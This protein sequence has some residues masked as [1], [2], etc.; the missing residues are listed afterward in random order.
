MWRYPVIPGTAPIP[1]TVLIPVLNIFF[2]IDLQ[3]EECEKKLKK[4]LS[5]M[6]TSTNISVKYLG[7]FGYQFLLYRY[8]Y[9][10]SAWY[11]YWY[12]FFNAILRINFLFNLLQISM[13]MDNLAKF[14]MKKED[15]QHTELRL[16]LNRPQSEP[17][18]PWSAFRIR[19]LFKRIRNMI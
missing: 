15:Y 17:L 18:I 16:I 4:R 19:F 10:S 8:R 5:R 14:A 12:F 13:H 7:F 11:D 6:N 9:G 3:C 2:N 1:G